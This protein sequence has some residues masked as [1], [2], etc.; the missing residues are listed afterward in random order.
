LAVRA[1]VFGVL[2]ERHRTI[3]R[4]VVILSTWVLHDRFRLAA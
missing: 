4:L 1:T 2:A 3:R